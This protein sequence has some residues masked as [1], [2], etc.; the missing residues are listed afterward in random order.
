LRHDHQLASG[1]LCAYWLPGSADPVLLKGVT[2]PE[3]AQA[4]VRR[5]PS[6]HSPLFAPVIDPTLRTGIAALTSA[7]RAWLGGTGEQGG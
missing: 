3:E 6:N 4:I 1:A 5:L 2:S 7:V